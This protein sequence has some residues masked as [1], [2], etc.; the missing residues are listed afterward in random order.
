MRV[1]HSPHDA[2]SPLLSVHCDPRP[3]LH[4]LHIPIQPRRF[5]AAPCRPQH[6]TRVTKPVDALQ[7]AAVLKQFRLQISTR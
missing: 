7:T 6:V 1:R 5:S 4:I 3:Q 2:T